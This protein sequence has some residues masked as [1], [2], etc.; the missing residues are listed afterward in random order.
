MILGLGPRRM[1]KSKEQRS[2]LG[3]TL[4]ARLGIFRLFKAK[5]FPHL[6]GNDDK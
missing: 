5:Q 4:L 3:E 2:E 6:A 1:T